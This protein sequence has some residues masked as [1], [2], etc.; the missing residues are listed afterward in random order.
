L[1]FDKE[2]DI[3]FCNIVSAYGVDGYLEAKQIKIKNLEP[4]LGESVVKG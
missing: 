2:G 4:F 3:K 1:K